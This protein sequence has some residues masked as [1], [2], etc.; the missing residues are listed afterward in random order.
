MRSQCL[1]TLS[2][3][4]GVNIW[5]KVA[6]VWEEMPIILLRPT[7]FLS[8]SYFQGVKSIDCLLNENCDNLYWIIPKL[9][10]M[11][12][13]GSPQCSGPQNTA[14]LMFPLYSTYWLSCIIKLSP[15][16]CMVQL[17]Q[18][19]CWRVNLVYW[20]SCIWKGLRLQPAQQACYSSCYL[21]WSVLVFIWSLNS[22]VYRTGSARAVLLTVMWLIY[23]F[24]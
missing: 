2:E 13:P 18:R 1:E 16:W 23:W 11:F 22:D 4:W 9:Y 19:F 17:F 3:R 5:W 8:S 14:V 12:V 7:S 6:K 15:L 20:W 21:S 10:L 24:I